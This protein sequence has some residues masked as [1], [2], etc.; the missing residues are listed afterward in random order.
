M[1]ISPQ[2]FYH[3]HSSKQGG[4]EERGGGAGGRPAMAAAAGE[5]RRGREMAKL[6]PC[7]RIT[8]CIPPNPRRV[9][10]IVAVHGL[11]DGP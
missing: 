1:Y 11:L 3:L 9:G 10:N 4:K 7:R 2:A 8:Q 5:G 6:I